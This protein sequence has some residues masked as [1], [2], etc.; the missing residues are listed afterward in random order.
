LGW[1]SEPGELAGVGLGLWVGYFGVGLSLQMGYFG[2]GRARKGGPSSSEPRRLC[3]SRCHVSFLQKG[4]RVSPAARE[5][6]CCPMDAEPLSDF[7]FVGLSI[8]NGP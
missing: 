3:S 2:V 8:E 1:A 7:L 5:H 6:S 4:L